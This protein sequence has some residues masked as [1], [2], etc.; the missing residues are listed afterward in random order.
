[1]Q[2]E[3]AKRQ[4]QEQSQRQ[5]I[6]MRDQWRQGRLKRNNP[7]TRMLII[8]SIVVTLFSGGLN[9]GQAD[10]AWLRQLM[11]ADSE[12]VTQEANQILRESGALTPAD[13]QR[14]ASVSL[15]TH[16]W[17]LWRLVTPNFHPCVGGRW[18]RHSPSGF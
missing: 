8:L 12:L 18:S 17:E 15:R 2:L 5:H 6:E 11:F 14:L 16:P 4:Q 7:L 10:N 9:S 3:E 13:H 1:M